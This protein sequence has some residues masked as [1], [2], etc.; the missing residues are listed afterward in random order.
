MFGRAW[1]EALVLAILIG[2][3]VR[4]VWQ[5]A[6]RWHAGINFSAKTLLEIAVVLLGASLSAQTLREAGAGLLAGIVAVVGVAIVVSYGTG[7]LLGLHHRMALLV[8]CGNSICGNSA[9]AAVA[10]VIRAHSD[11]VA[12]SIAF[13]AVLG[14]IVVLGLP[15]LIPLLHLS[16]LQYGVLAGLTVYAV[17][18]VLAATIPVSA[19]STHLGTLVKLVRV[20]MLGPVILVL[21]IGSRRAG[22]APLPGA[23]KK[24]RFA[25][26]KVVPWFIIGFLALVALRS[27]NVFPAAV[28][29]PISSAA[30]VLTIISM[31]ALG[32]GVDVRMVAKAGPRVTLAVVLSIVALALIS[33]VLIRV[34]GM[35]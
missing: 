6:P 7:R 21:S 33:L 12:A 34:L 26:H 27:A 22:A 2:T 11:D 35:V 17:P 32:L 31:A 18:Q 10:P 8:A 14:V 13:T 29:P 1:L 5:P 16:N 20:L 3:A 30:N 4:S 25:W 28:L 15:L 9:I 19:V 23:S 24:A